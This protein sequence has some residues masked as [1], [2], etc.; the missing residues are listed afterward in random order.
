M[1]F[2]LMSHKVQ[3]HIPMSEAYLSI[4]YNPETSCCSNDNS[5]LHSTIFWSTVFVIEPKSASATLHPHA[6][7][8]VKSKQLAV[9]LHESHN[10]L[11]ITLQEPNYHII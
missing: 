2:T 9:H 4:Q 3:L 7:S 1:S 5:W 11:N 8:F 10:T 6:T